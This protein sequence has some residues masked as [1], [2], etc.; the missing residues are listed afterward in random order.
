MPLSD[1]TGVDSVLPEL[2]LPRYAE[3]V[4]AERHTVD[5]VAAQI[6]ACIV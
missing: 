2:A 4:D 6:R 1:T 3:H 5:Q